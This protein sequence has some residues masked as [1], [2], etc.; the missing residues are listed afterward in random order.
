M[1]RCFR[2]AAAASVVALALLAVACAPRNAEPVPFTGAGA[3][4][5][6]LLT[7]DNQDYR[8]ATV[9]A[10]WNGVNHRVGTV[11]GKTT[12]TFTIAWRDYQV[13]LEV[14][15]LGGGEMKLGDLIAVQPGE[16][17]DFVIMPGW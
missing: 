15:F 5:T 17:L 16:H 12:E 9:Y 7:V 11:T 6:M 14:D 13:R 3:D 10:N 2:P 8:D 4:P 1:Q